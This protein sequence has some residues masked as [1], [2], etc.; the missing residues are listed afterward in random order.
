M[1]SLWDTICSAE[2]DKEME[3]YSDQKQEFLSNFLELANEILS[4]HTIN[5]VFRF[6]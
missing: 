3:N 6:F 1:L 4:Q 2:N 5:R